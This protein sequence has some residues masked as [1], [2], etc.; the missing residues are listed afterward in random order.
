M[1]KKAGYSREK[2]KILAYNL[3]AG[4][5]GFFSEHTESSLVE[6]VKVKLFTIKEKL[7]WDSVKVVSIFGKISHDAWSELRDVTDRKWYVI[8]IHARICTY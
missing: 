2:E 7:V 1:F 8:I 3:K 6:D 5:L 4:R